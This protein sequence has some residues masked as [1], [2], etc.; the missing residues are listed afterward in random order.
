MPDT[1]LSLPKVFAAPETPF[2][3]FQ[4]ASFMRDQLN[5]IAPEYVFVIQE[6]PIGGFVVQPTRLNNP[7]SSFYKPEEK[8]VSNTSTMDNLS[9]ETRAFF[10]DLP[11][12]LR[13]A[14]RI[15]F[16]RWVAAFLFAALATFSELL[17]NAYLP[18]ISIKFPILPS[19]LFWLLIAIAFYHFAIVIKN[20]YSNS[21]TITKDGIISRK[22]IIA[23]DTHT[24]KF[25]HIRTVVLKQGVLERLFNVGTLEFDTVAGAEGADVVFT[26]IAQPAR[27]KGYLTEY[28]NACH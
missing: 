20:L 24:V 13:P 15:F 4:S 28:L 11:T 19:I 2:P 21:Y 7:S 23:R 22:G 27:I 25:E 8:K 9:A 1:Q 6:L 3:D 17:L 5:R 12:V 16:F 10:A 18:N 14:K 26:D